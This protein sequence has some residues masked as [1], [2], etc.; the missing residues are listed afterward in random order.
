MQLHFLPIPRASPWHAPRE[1]LLII[2][3][4]LDILIGFWLILANVPVIFVYALPGTV[5]REGYA[6]AVPDCSLHDMSELIL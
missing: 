3:T 6:D 1:G 5:H 2:F 4:F